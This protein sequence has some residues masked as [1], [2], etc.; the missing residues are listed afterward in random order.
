[1]TYFLS[2]PFFQ[3]VP[4]FP[5]RLEIRLL[6]EDLDDVHDGEKPGFRLLIVEPADFTIFENGGDDFHGFG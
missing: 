5:S 3:F 4:V 1:L 2:Q 6:R